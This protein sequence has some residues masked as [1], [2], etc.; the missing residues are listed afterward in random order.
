MLLPRL[1]SVL[2]YAER[3]R[4]FDDVRADILDLLAVLRF[5]GDET[6]SDQAAEVKRDLRAIAVGR[7]DW[8]AVL[9]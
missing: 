2:A 7:R 8:R 5:D 6:V 4:E 1:S 9:S 3:L